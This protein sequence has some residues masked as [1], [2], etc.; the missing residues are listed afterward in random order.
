MVKFALD[1]DSPEYTTLRTN[2]NISLFFRTRSPDGFLFYLGKADGGNYIMSELADSAV[3]LRVKLVPQLEAV[4]DIPGYYSDGV[5]YFY[6]IQRTN[7]D[8]SWEIKPASEMGITGS[9]RTQDT[10]H[11]ITIYLDPEFFYLGSLTADGGNES[12]RKRRQAQPTSLDVSANTT[13]PFHGTVQDARLNGIS[14]AVFP[15]N[16]TGIPAFDSP[17][18]TGDVREGEVS[19]DICAN[20]T[21]QNG[22]TCQNVFYSDYQ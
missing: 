2:T 18:I 16:N 4:F 13:D 14:L 11:P 1:S 19:D 6:D 20:H 22:G 15:Q 9:L 10:I 21:C 7:E 8:I 17:E 3:K 5:Q 12:R